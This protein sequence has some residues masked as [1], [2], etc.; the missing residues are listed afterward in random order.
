MMISDFGLKERGIRILKG[1]GSIEV[2]LQ[3]R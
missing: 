3:S 1:F 2:G